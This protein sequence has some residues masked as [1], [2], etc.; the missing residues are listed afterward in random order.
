MQSTSPLDEAQLSI[1]A[2]TREAKRKLR[3]AGLIALS[4]VIGLGLCGA[5]A[6]GFG[7]LGL[8][9]STIGLVLIVLAWNEQRGRS[10]L[11]AGDSRA[12]R[13]LALNQLLLFGAV[14]V[15]CAYS[16][17]VAWTGPSVLDAVSRQLPELPE[18]FEGILGA[19]TS[20]ADLSE[21]GRMVALGFYA[22]VAIGSL[23][24]QG[25]TALYYQ[26]LRS[27]VEALAALPAWARE[28]A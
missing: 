22:A 9:L 20:V 26:S 28:L 25:L 15:Y 3:F 1:L 10:L 21:W 13:R 24:V 27:T 14:F 8:G 23:L 19:G 4:N 7:L 17:Y 16:A 5:I 6:L 2:K 18:A 12:P 11:L